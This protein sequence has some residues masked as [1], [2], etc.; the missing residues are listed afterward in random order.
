MQPTNNEPAGAFATARQAAARLGLPI[1]FLVQEARASRI[2]HLRA[3]RRVLFN[4]KAVEAALLARAEG[5]D[6]DGH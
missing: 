4:V 6:A 1:A 5:K 3:G 2:P